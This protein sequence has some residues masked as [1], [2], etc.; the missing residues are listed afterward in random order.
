MQ[1][2]PRSLTVSESINYHPKLILTGAWLHHFGFTIGDVVSVT[3]QEPGILVVKMEMPAIEA[4][5]AKREKQLKLQVTTAE[6][7]LE[8]LKSLQQRLPGS[9]GSLSILDPKQPAGKKNG[10]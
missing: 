8:F 10:G 1:N 7:E 5:H 9:Y 2:K 4:L 6:T 3:C